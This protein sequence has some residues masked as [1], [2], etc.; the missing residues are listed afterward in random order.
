MGAACV[1]NVVWYTP[2]H[3]NGDASCMF[4][5]NLDLF[6]IFNAY[7]VVCDI[8]VPAACAGRREKTRS[9]TVFECKVFFIMINS[10]CMLCMVAKRY[11]ADRKFLMCLWLHYIGISS[12]RPGQSDPHFLCMLGMKMVKM[13]GNVEWRRGGVIKGR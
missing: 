3:R 12:M 7:V 13:I 4:F 5:P 2:L 8:E 9:N 6:F 11:R 1:Y 10:P